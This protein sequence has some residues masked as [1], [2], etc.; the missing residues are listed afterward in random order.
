[1]P[2]TQPAERKQNNLQLLSVID[3]F[4]TIQ[5]EGPYSGRPAIF[6]RLAGC[7]LTC[8][9]CDTD[10]TSDRHTL[11][12]QETLWL[13]RNKANRTKEGALPIVVITGGEPFRQAA[14]VPLVKELIEFVVQIETN[15]SYFFP[16]IH[17][18][19][20]VVCCPKTPYV[21]VKNVHY[22]KYV[23]E[24]G[25]VDKQDGLP[26]SVLGHSIAPCRPPSEVLP[27]NIFVQPVDTSNQETNK[28]NMKA[29]VDS[30][31]RFGYRLC[32]QQHKI[33]GLP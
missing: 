2:N 33:A 17:N 1:M 11:S 18:Y 25:F 29:A 8:R 7:N 27:E 19:A 32:L 30:C 15:G 14:I 3:C 23:I 31:L 28:R 26:T 13:I 20:T 24:H 5:G 16:Y 4:Y 21:Q 10:Y 22:W 12:V 9:L 6:L